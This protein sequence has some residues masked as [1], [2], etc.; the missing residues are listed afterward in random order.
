MYFFN[1]QA[2][3]FNGNFRISGYASL[4][5]QIT[6]AKIVFWERVYFLGVLKSSLRISYPCSRILSNLQDIDGGTFLVT[7]IKKSQLIRR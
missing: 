6:M 7:D 1:A 3:H 5:S 2:E 4:D